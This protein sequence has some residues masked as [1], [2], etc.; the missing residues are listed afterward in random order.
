VTTAEDA[1]SISVIETSPQSAYAADPDVINTAAAAPFNKFIFVFI[2]VS[3][4]VVSP[5]LFSPSEPGA[6]GVTWV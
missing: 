3:P 6:A 1:Q 4:K 5:F 2:L